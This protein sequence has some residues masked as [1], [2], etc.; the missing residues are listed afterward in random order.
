M[1]VPNHSSPMRH[2]N[3]GITMKP[4]RAGSYASKACSASEPR[5]GSG[6]LFRSCFVGPRVSVIVSEQGLRS[7]GSPPLLGAGDPE[8]KSRRPDQSM[9]FVSDHLVKDTSEVNHPFLFRS[10]R[11]VR[12]LR[13]PPTGNAPYKRVLSVLA[14]RTNGNFPL[15]R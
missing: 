13:H 1:G 15:A 2:A 7:L 12:T 5:T 6:F 8:F 11:I 9:F 10:L 14:R 3:A 4:V